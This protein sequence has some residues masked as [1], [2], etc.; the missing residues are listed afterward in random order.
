MSALFYVVTSVVAGLLGAL[1]PVTRIPEIVLQL[2]QFGP[3]IGV[4]C[5]FLFFRRETKTLL[6]GR[7]DFEPA[8]V[9]RV[10]AAVGLAGGIFALSLLYYALIGKD[11]HYTHPGSLAQPFW[12]IVIFQFIG[13]ASEEF[14]WRCFLQPLLQTR[15]RVVTSSLVVG[16]LWGLWH[17]GVFA[18]GPGYA[19][20]FMV[21]AIAISVIM[22]ELLRTVRR[23]NLFAATT[24]HALLN[25][26]L[27]LLF[28]EETGDISS[29]TIFAGACS[30]VAVGAVIYNRMR[31]QP[32]TVE[33]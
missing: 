13:A 29:M 12:I 7:L 28:T 4:L 31:R 23:S 30:I 20:S 24:L 25:L 26:G 16:V 11:A 5:A 17:V 1:Q 3:T 18:E 2:T 32:L 21:S 27:L 19:A 33:S 9:K 22:G 15:L 14:G 10:V 6:S 8:I